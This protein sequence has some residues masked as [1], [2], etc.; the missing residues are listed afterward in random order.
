MLSA[1]F[2]DDL[3]YNNAFYAK[4][5]GVTVVEINSLELELLSLI[6]FSLYVSS[7]QYDKYQCELQSYAS[8]VNVPANIFPVLSG[9]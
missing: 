2:F 5:G 1:K 6:N 3:F 8:S 9:N 4:L 7:D